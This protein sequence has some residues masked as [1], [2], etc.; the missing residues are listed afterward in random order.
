MDKHSAVGYKIEIF[1][2]EKK[3]NYLNETAEEI[4]HKNLKIF[5]ENRTTEY[6]ERRI[7]FC[8]TWASYG[9]SNAAIFMNTFFLII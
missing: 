5:H 2:T 1:L 7:E 6:N 8:Y 4:E 3:K 9:W